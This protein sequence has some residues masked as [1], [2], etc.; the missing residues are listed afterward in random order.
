MKTWYL[1]IFIS[2][3]HLFA[4]VG[5]PQMHCL[6][7][8]T[9]GDVTIFW[10]PPTDPG[11]QFFEYEIFNSS[12]QLGPFTSIATITSIAT[13]SYV[14]VGAGANTQSKYY[15]I[16]TKFGPGGANTSKNSDTLRSIFLNLINSNG[17][18]G[19]NFNHLKQPPLSTSSP[20]FTIL[21]EHPPG[22]WSNLKITQGLSYNDT[23][24]V[25]NV[26]Y[27]YLVTLGDSKGCLSTSN[28]SGGT[29]QDKIG[30]NPTYIDSVSVLPNGQTVIG[31]PPS[32]SS[33]CSGYYIYQVI[34]SINTKIDSL[35]G[36]L[37]TLYTFTSTSANSSEVKFIIAPFD[38]C[39][40]P[41][42][43]NTAHKTM[44]LVANYN[45]CKYETRLSWNAYENMRNGI[46]EYKIYYS[47]NG[48][49]FQLLGSTPG[50][51]FTHSN[52]DPD[53]TVTYFV[54]AVNGTED[55]TS[56]SNR[57]TFFS[58]QTPAPDFIY[59]KSVSVL[60]D[61]NIKIKFLVDSIKL[62]NGFDLYRSEDGISFTKIGFIAS[63]ATNSYEYTDTD[64]KTRSK[65]Y[66]YKAMAKDS[67]GNDRTTSS[68]VQAIL[69]KVNND[70]NNFFH[71][72]LSW[73]NYTGFAG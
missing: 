37:S 32:I 44:F 34:N 72:K 60:D 40:N 73:S 22:T 59:I 45:K 55:I 2:I 68:V 69:L 38:S 50:L 61:E 64:L 43:L 6:S 39:G 36:A 46:K 56:S 48:G 1:A 62:G 35:A 7:T 10:T 53:K 16:R 49:N 9:I 30:P 17:V 51:T 18:V 71:K 19:I 28:I 31:Y 54:R 63:L 12:F 47:V 8:N 20:S 70:K 15:F 58:Y 65:T 29:Y 57:V 33:D 52:V 14:H 27:N 24:S 13:N 67:C 21:R 5:P 66:F 4:Q 41:G 42:I 23:I 25:C 26:S 3:G 11:A